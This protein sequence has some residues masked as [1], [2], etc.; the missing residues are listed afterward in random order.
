M[1][2]LTLCVLVLM[3]PSAIGASLD[4]LLTDVKVLYLYEN[5]SAIDWP[6]IYY[7]SNE[8][9]CRVDLATIDAAPS[10]SSDRRLSSDANVSSI[11][12]TVTDTSRVS[13]ERALASMCGYRF[14]DI[15]IFGEVFRGSHLRAFERHL[16]SGQTTVNAVLGIKKFYRRTDQSSPSVIYVNGQLYYNRA[17]DR[18]AALAT[19]LFEIPPLAEELERYTVYEL[20]NS[21]TKGSD[22]PTGFLS[23][24]EPFK[25]E[26]LIEQRIVSSYLRINMLDNARQYQSYLQS[27]AETIGGKRIEAMLFA[28]SELRKILNA[29]YSAREEDPGGV[30]ESYLSR[31]VA[32]AVDAVFAEAGVSHRGD[33]LF[34]RSPEGTRLKFVS[35]ITNDGPLE[36]DF[37]GVTAS[38][39]QSDTAFVIDSAESKILPFSSLIR[40]YTIA[41]PLHKMS[42]R[43]PDSLTLTGKIGYRNN[44][45]DFAYQVGAYKESPLRVRI[46]PD[47]VMGQPFAEEQIDRLVDATTI[48][49]VIEKPTD[50]AGEVKIR[51]ATPEGIL[52][53]AFEENLTLVS[54][55]NAYEFS[56]PLVA[57]KSIGNKRVKLGVEILLDGQVAASD[58]VYVGGGDCAVDTKLKVAL[59]PGAEGLAEDL[60]RMTGANYRIL[61]DRYLEAGDLDFFDVI[62]FETGCDERYHALGSVGTRLKKYM[63]YGGGIIV[64]GQPSNWRDD[65]LP[66]TITSTAER[67]SAKDATVLNADHS[68]FNLTHTVNVLQLLQNIGQSYISYPAL[69]FPAERIIERADNTALLSESEFGRGRF[70][71]CGL[72]ILQMIRQIDPEAVKFFA[73]LVNFAGK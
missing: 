72:P 50:F 73:N 13:L 44:T 14:P 1:T 24:I 6:L 23:G 45:V 16:L 65:L 21:A 18:I 22:I 32:D 63:D 46:I 54:G 19:D 66:V 62:I 36:L 17:S 61:S 4:N 35:T 42:A 10:P 33:M 70:I 51:F 64:F 3:M 12:C 58:H 43:T 71:Y 59:A 7:L 27:A 8:N 38:L 15:V 20:I 28:V 68:L 52:I 55:D 53:G 39:D 34:R 2:I 5:Q 40:E 48:N 49:I 47:F 41:L 37:Y 29:F 9:H 30:F 31:A 57:R 26:E 67:L 25:L 11:H 69:V 60:L 56:I